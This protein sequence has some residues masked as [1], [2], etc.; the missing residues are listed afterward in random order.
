[1]DYKPT[2]Q[3]STKIS[4]DPNKC[5]VEKTIFDLRNGNNNQKIDSNHMGWKSEATKSHVSQVDMALRQNHHL[6][7]SH[8]IRRIGLQE[9]IINN[10]DKNCPTTTTTTKSCTLYHRVRRKLKYF[11]FLGKSG[12]ELNSR[13]YKLICYRKGFESFRAAFLNNKLQW[14]PHQSETA[15]LEHMATLIWRQVCYILMLYY[16]DTS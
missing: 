2:V 11:F 14:N 5:L 6:T 10:V 9:G 7:T 16:S 4:Y 12:K 8:L 15:E 1:M 3:K 13:A